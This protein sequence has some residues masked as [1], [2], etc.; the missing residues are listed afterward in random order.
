MY[1]YI[2]GNNPKRPRYYFEAFWKQ[3]KK[4]KRIIHEKKRTTLINPIK[5]IYLS[6]YLYI[7][8]SDNNYQITN[9]NKQLS[10]V[11]ND[12]SSEYGSFNIREHVSIK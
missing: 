3:R 11:K 9:T 5:Y 1:E 8:Y 7:F 10:G 4:R 6:I 2:A 12:H